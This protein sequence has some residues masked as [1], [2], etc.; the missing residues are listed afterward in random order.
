M[1]PHK[2]AAAPTHTAV[3]ARWDSDAALEAMP[4]TP[5]AGQALH[6]ASTGQ[7]QTRSRRSAKDLDGKMAIELATKPETRELI[8][9]YMKKQGVPMP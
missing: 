6:N 7:D 9:K 8:M 2:P 3:L 4:I 1:K 5:A